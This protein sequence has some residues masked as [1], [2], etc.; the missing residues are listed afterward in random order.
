MNE[1]ELFLESCRSEE[2]KKQ[3]ITHL[4][5]WFNFIGSELSFDN[6]NRKKI[7]DEIIKYIVY[8]KKLGKSRAAIHN[9][10]EPVYS[11]YSINDIILNR[12]KLIN[13]FLNIGK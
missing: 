11:L 2:T 6:S 8:L 10:I 9:Y 7:E 12:K 13:S 3:Y 5:K 4:K 1:V